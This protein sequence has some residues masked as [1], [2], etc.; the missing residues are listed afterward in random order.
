MKEYIVEYLVEIAVEANDE[1]EAKMKAEN[2]MSMLD[3]D[4]SRIVNVQEL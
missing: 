1:M 4:S 3:C 2:E